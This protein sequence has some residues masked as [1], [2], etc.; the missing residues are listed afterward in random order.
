MS[1]ENSPGSSQNKDSSI[2]TGRRYGIFSGVGEKAVMLNMSAEPSEELSPNENNTDDARKTT[3]ETIV[4]Q[5]NSEISET[6]D[7]QTDRSSEENSESEHSTR[8][9]IVEDQDPRQYPDDPPKA[10]K[11]F[12]GEQSDTPADHIPGDN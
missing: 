6:E 1:L 8:E 5:L 2:L 7:S 12:Y 3:E 4:E 11:D 9:W 10:L